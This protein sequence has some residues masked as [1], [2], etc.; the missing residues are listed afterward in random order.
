LR[1][2]EGRRVEEIGGSSRM[3]NVGKKEARALYSK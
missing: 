2:K 3:K 1:G